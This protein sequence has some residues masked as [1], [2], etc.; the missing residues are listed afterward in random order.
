V[1][2]LKR[3]FAPGPRCEVCG[4]PATGFAVK[5]RPRPAT[6]AGKPATDLKAAGQP[7]NLCPAHLKE[8][9]EDPG[10]FG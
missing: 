10:G 4:K 6:E 3:L 2:W 7:I 9:R 5:V 1:G 8:Y